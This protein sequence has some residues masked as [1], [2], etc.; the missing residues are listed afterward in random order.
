M[1]YKFYFNYIQ[2]VTTHFPPNMSELNNISTVL[3]WHWKYNKKHHDTYVKFRHI[4]A[5]DSFPDPIHGSPLTW[6]L[7]SRTT[8]F[9][10]LSPPSFH[11]SFLP[12]FFCLSV[13]FT[14]PEYKH[15]KLSPSL[16]ISDILPSVYVCFR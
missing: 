7:F 6:W 13:F 10:M 4:F 8:M 2:S 12:F 5:M 3:P 11:F 14:Y 15:L 1:S 16:Q 9:C